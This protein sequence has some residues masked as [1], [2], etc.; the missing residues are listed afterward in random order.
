MDLAQFF[1]GPMPTCYVAFAAA[2]DHLEKKHCVC[3]S[4]LSS[5][6]FFFQATNHI[7]R[8]AT[9]SKTVHNSL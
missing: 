6:L 2:S 3:A 9:V 4:F 8:V 7:L 1:L 5:L